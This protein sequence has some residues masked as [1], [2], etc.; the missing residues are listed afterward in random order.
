MKIKVGGSFQR[1][2]TRSLGLIGDTWPENTIND[3]PV[4]GIKRERVEPRRKLVGTFVARFHG[5]D[6]QEVSLER[7]IM[8]HWK[9]AKVI[10]LDL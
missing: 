5:L 8:N 7:S 4:A 2:Q 10:R 1:Y 6:L 3:S 9:W